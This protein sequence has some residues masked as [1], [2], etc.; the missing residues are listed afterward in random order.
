MHGG[1]WLEDGDVKWS[2]SKADGW[3]KSFGANSL[4]SVRFAPQ[5]VWYLSKRVHASGPP[6]ILVISTDPDFVLTMHEKHAD[7]GTM[8]GAFD[9]DL[10]ESLVRLL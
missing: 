2:E 1:A 9:Y 8:H 3:F 4:R 7:L 5:P 6:A 10:V